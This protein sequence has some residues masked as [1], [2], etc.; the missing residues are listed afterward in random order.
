M[1]AMSS[2][3]G[4]FPHLAARTRAAGRSAQ[5]D[6]A[7]VRFELVRLVSDARFADG[8]RCVHCSGRRVIRWG[9]YRE[10]FRYHCRECGRTFNA[11]SAT[12]FAYSKKL[13]LWPAYLVLMRSQT[14]LRRA[15]A[16]VGIH[17][18]TSFRWRHRVLAAFGAPEALCGYVEL[19]EALFPYSEKGS[20][21]LVHRASHK[22]GGYSDKAEWTT[23][24][25]VRVLLFVSRTGSAAAAI[26]LGRVPV[27][28]HV[29]PALQTLLVPSASVILPSECNPLYRL[30]LERRG[31]A[32]LTVLR[33]DTWRVKIVHAANV[34]AFE[35]RLRAWLMPFRG[36][37][38]KYLHRYLA[39]HR[40][41]ER[42]ELQ[43]WLGTLIGDVVS[44][45][46]N[47]HE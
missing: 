32:T 31:R 34:H 11:L 37:A 42:D 40:F 16:R 44:M 33:R 15:A 19:K 36:V 30:A 28:P 22:R 25:R 12:P 29:E 14:T 45:G 47:D 26:F 38:T 39:W 41:A 27:L 1:L 2:A 3:P 7:R 9:R 24:R 10:W 20:R 5:V 46:P 8:L 23:R 43:I 35:R 21:R 18:S 6:P 4:S 17:L 13:S